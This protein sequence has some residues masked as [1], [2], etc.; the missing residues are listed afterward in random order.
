MGGISGTGGLALSIGKGPFT[1]L[2]LKPT[3]LPAQR[4]RS[5]PPTHLSFNLYFLAQVT[6]S[7]SGTP[8]SPT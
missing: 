1:M 8:Y 6:L 5:L 3:L 2:S 4:K 7:W